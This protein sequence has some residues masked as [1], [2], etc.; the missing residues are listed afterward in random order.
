M[1]TKTITP[2]PT[3]KPLVIPYVP[4][5]PAHA[6][7]YGGNDLPGIYDYSPS[8][9]TGG[10]GLGD[11]LAS[12]IGGG[13]APQAQANVPQAQQ[14]APVASVAPA[15]PMAAAAPPATLSNPATL[16]PGDGL[17][18]PV[19]RPLPPRPTDL[20]APTPPPAP[21]T[22]GD[23]SR[24][25]QAIQAAALLPLLNLLG[26]GSAIANASAASNPEAMAQ[27]LYGN[28]AYSDKA[29]ADQLNQ[30]G[31]TRQYG[32]DVNAA[33]L[34]AWS[35]DIK[36]VQDANAEENKK[37][38]LSIKQAKQLSSLAPV[39]QKAIHDLSTLKDDAS[40]QAYIDS[41][42]LQQ[43][44]ITDPQSLARIAHFYPSVKTPEEKAAAARLAE[45]V[46][47]YGLLKAN[48]QQLTPEAQRRITA[49][50]AANNAAS[51]I[52]D[53]GAEDTAIGQLYKG[54]SD[55]QRVMSD[56]RQAR[57]SE[58]V[59]HDKASEAT[60]ADRAA[61]YAD[62][63]K[64]AQDRADWYGKNVASIMNAK[65]LKAAGVDLSTH[66]ISTIS[67]LNSKIKAAQK[68]QAIQTANKAIFQNVGGDFGASQT[69]EADTLI[70]QNQEFIDKAQGLIDAL[71][72]RVKQPKGAVAPAAVTLPAKN[73]G[74]PATV[75][76]GYNAW[77]AKGRALGA[78]VGGQ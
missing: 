59:R 30:Y 34:G 27:S 55:A 24:Q 23:Q 40:R 74:G 10:G 32:A 15:T 8:P 58:Q 67:T 52:V 51:G 45:N 48:A 66:A 77:L 73:L 18:D 13:A 36:N 35:A 76:T 53:A 6:G 9:I 63:A 4:G 50:I 5:A 61:T 75:D 7:V 31:L 46:Q 47:L 56:V 39:E 22:A 20:I 78:P 29:R 25:Q 11:W 42:Y 44:G 62:M 64:T 28:E 37:A 41:G 21:D 70:R 60:A 65:A 19:I 69:Q 14:S 17:Y 1:A 26:G 54:Q 68:E 43:L 38:G 33:K 57:Q 3:R 71:R 49:R 2:G 16:A 72:P 12:L